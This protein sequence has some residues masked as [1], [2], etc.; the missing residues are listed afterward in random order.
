M[1]AR[2][3]MVRSVVTTTPETTVEKV[4]RLMI[5]LRISGVPVL[6]KNGRLVGIVTEGDLLRRAETGT[7]HRRSRW[8]EWFS[9]NSRLAAEYIKSHARRVED[10]MTR[11]VVSV[12]ELA[13]LGEIAELMETKRIKRVP[14][15][16]DGKIIGIVSRADLLQVLAS[17]GATPANEDSDR[18]IRERLLAEL[19][20]QEWASPT[21]SS[22]IVSDGVV[23]F[24]GTVASEQ[25]RTALRVVAENIP[26]VR[27]IEDH[28]SSGPRYLTPLFP[29]A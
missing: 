24:W 16:H 17:G 26:G 20:K 28:T 11:E 19:R 5:N 21:E 23:H 18:L 25:E 29:A 3:V 10:V 6:N 27:S 9:T 15:A 13:S 22:V 7:E 2:D 1:R 12:G 14:V 4:A 8:S